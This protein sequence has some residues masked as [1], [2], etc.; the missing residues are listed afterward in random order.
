MIS[1]Y[2][3]IDIG[4]FSINTSN[5]MVSQNNKP[6]KGFGNWPFHTL[7]YVQTSVQTRCLVPERWQQK[8]R[9]VHQRKP[10]LTGRWRLL[11][12]HL[13]SCRCSLVENEYF[14]DR[15]PRSFS[16]ILNFYRTGKLHLVEEMC[17]LAFSDDLD[18]WA[19]DELYLEV[20]I[21]TLL[22]HCTFHHL[23]TPCTA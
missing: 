3:Q 17:V 16:S 15:H 11:L 1:Y 20:C 19:I 7:I 13:H 5:H 22:P 6:T 8:P 10:P 2:G 12:K 14:F 4:I 18:Y 21:M 23:M 9:G